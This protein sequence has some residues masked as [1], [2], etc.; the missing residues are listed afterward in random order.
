MR[1][2]QARHA[3][4]DVHHRA[5]RE[6]ERAV[7]E[8]PAR[9]MPHPVRDGAVDQQR[10]ERDE[11]HEGRELHA[12]GD[13]AGDQRGGDDREGHLEHRE[14]AFGMVKATVASPVPMVKGLS[15]DSSIP[16]ISTREKSPK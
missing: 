7:H 12:I 10:P 5:A 4:V 6:V 8:Q 11:Q 15:Q 2:H 3:R 9:G 16:R 14:E 13:R 1:R